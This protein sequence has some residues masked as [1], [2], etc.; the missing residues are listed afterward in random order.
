MQK[1]MTIIQIAELC[2]MSETTIRRWASEAS[3]TMAEL[4]AKMADAQDSKVPARFTKPEVLAIVRAGGKNTLADLLEDNA[5]QRQALPSGAQLRELRLMAAKNL[6]TAAQLQVL[7][8]IPQRPAIHP[9]PARLEAPEKYTTREEA[10]TRL[11][12]IRHKL[13]RQPEL[14]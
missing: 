12:D 13:T 2:D 5:E 7:L 6:I 9:P 4:R 10:G 14:L 3:A 1:D 11:A 8:G